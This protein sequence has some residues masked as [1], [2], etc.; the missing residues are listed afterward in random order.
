VRK[1][2]PR[3]RAGFATGDVLIVLSI[4][5]VGAAMV[6]PRLQERRFRERLDEVMAHVEAVR[7]GAMEYF[8]DQRGWP[9]PAEP[10]RV[11]S[12]LA[13]LLPPGFAFTNSGYTFEWRRWETVQ[14]P[15]DAGLAE[16]PDVPELPELPELLNVGEPVVDT[17]PSTRPPTIRTIAALT[18]HAGDDAILVELLDFYGSRASFVRDTTWTLMMPLRSDPVGDTLPPTG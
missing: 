15:P 9:A 10:G 4:L 17:T 3:S 1:A 7:T 16:L 12:E 8:T 13:S 11:P 2:S 6:Y 5:S 14:A 18:V